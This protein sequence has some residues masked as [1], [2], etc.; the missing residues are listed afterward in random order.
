MSCAK[1]TCTAALLHRGGAQRHVVEHEPAGRPRLV[2]G[3]SA[4]RIR[5]QQEAAP[6]VWQR[7]QLADHLQRNTLS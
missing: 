1:I 6:Q 7:Q 4:L 2:H 3:G 5:S